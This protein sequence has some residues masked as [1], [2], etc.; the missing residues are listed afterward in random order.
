MNLNFAKQKLNPAKQELNFLRSKKLNFSKNLRFVIKT[1]I[2]VLKEK[3][4][5]SPLREKLHE[6][7]YEADTAMGRY[8]DVALLICILISVMLVMLESVDAINDKYHT[9]LF[10]L[11][12]FFT[13]VF[14]IEYILRLYSVLKPWKYAFSFFG[15]IDLLAILPAFLGLILASTQTHFL[16]TIR[17]LRLLRIFRIFKA[18]KYLNE[19]SA[20]AS[21]LYASRRKI[22]VF[23][24][25]ILLVAMIVGSVLYLVEADSNPAFANIPISI[26]W[27]IVTITTVGYGDISPITPLGQFLAAGL[28]I[29]GY[30]VIAVP[31]G[32]VSAEMVKEVTKE[33]EVTTISCRSCTKEGHDEDA[34]FCKYCGEAL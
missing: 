9:E 6:I 24:F 11:E 4:Q 33:Q 26:Y 21:S 17:A 18:A 29:M 30:A 19:S 15:I 12:W 28:M 2:V 22:L 32:I 31:T 23:L 34:D 5:M 16:V 10:V 1:D 3:K 14:T 27:A 25:F 8:F 20:L 7:I 13:I